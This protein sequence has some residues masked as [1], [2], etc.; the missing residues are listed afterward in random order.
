M[1]KFRHIDTFLKVNCLHPCLQSG[2]LEPVTQT[3]FPQSQPPTPVPMDPKLPSYPSQFPTSPSQFP[4]EMATAQGMS[5]GAPRMP[6]PGN[7]VQPGMNRA[8]GVSNQLRLPPNQLRLQLQQRLQ[9]PQQVELQLSFH[10]A[11]INANAQHLNPPLGLC[12]TVQCFQF[13][14]FQI[15]CCG[16]NLFFCGVQLLGEGV[17][18]CTCL[19]VNCLSAFSLHQLQNRLAALGSFPQG[20]HVAMGMRQSIQQPQMA[21]QVG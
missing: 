20:G 16:T 21:S 14:P 19:A 2:C 10:C 8:P 13:Q 12:S 9:G 17:I 5:F 4:A 3:P 15:T 7:V 11:L 18:S 6:F 1:S